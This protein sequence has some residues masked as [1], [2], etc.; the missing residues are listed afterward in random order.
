MI[1]ISTSTSLSIEKAAKLLQNLV[2]LRD[3]GN[4]DLPGDV[5]KSVDSLLQAQKRFTKEIDDYLLRAYTFIAEDGIETVTTIVTFRG[6]V[7]PKT[8]SHYHV[9]NYVESVLRIS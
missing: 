1:P 4:V 9:G 5:F 8:L 2:D 6:R 3:K 7:K